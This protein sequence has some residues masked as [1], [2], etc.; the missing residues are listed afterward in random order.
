MSKPTQK[1][2]K[3][4]RDQGYIGDMIERWIIIP[5]IP[6][7]GKRK[8]YLG[9]GDILFFKPDESETLMVQS[10]GQNY[11]EHLRKILAEPMAAEWVK[12]KNRRLI[13]IGWRKILKKRGGKLKIWAPRIKEFSI[14]DFLGG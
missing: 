14:N 2:L 13:L 9:F 10:C 5:G 12:M 3:Y 6:G 4:F 8:D 7:K 11:A 1:T